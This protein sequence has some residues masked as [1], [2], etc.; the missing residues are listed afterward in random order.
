[1]SAA[2]LLFALSQSA[3]ACS[4]SMDQTAAAAVNQ[5]SSAIGA[6]ALSFDLLER[7]RVTQPAAETSL[8]NMADEIEKARKD[9]KENLPATADERKLHAE[10]DDALEHADAALGLARQALASKDAPGDPVD[11]PEFHAA[12]AALSASAQELDK[13][14]QRLGTGR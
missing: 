14:R 11:T 10:V 3:S 6:G 2:V 4:A 12:R 8:E 7:G 1:M 5:A 13:L 9:L